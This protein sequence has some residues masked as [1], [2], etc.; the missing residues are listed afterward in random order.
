M[1]SG[2]ARTLGIELRIAVLETAVLPLHYVRTLVAGRGFEPQFPES[3]SGVL[4]LDEP[5]K[6]RLGLVSH[7]HLLL[8][9]QALIYFSYQ[10]MV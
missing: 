7:Q 5:A 10:D 4:P 3:K 2:V 6:W 8:F 1:F 9:R